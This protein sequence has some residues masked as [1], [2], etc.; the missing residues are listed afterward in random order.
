MSDEPLYNIVRFASNDNGF[1]SRRIVKRGVTLEE[2]QAHCKDPET[3]S[4]TCKGSRG[5]KRAW[6]LGK[7]GRWFD[8]FEQ[9]RR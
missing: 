2:A 9:C 1:V 7:G 6:N 3:S 8:G 4:S 5:K